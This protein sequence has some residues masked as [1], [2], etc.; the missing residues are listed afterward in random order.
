[1]RWAPIHMLFS[2]AVAICPT[3]TNIIKFN[4]S[5]CNIDL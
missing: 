5:L 2:Q 4:W 3:H 1:M